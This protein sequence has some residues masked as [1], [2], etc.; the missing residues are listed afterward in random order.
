MASKDKFEHGR[1]PKVQPG[2][3]VWYRLV[4]KGY[5]GKVKNGCESQRSPDSNPPPGDGWIRGHIPKTDYEK[6]EYTRTRSALFTGRKMSPEWRAKMSQASKGKPK[7]EAHKAAM[8][9]A[10]KAAYARRKAMK[11]GE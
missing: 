11:G 9:I 10:S 8:S 7:S 5:V 4:Q 6:A 2:S 1:H 3:T